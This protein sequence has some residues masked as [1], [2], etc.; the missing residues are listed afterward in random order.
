MLSGGVRVELGA[1]PP[2]EDRQRRRGEILSRV[3]HYDGTQAGLYMGLLCPLRPPGNCASK[4]ARTSAVDTV[5]LRAKGGEGDL[6]GE[7]RGL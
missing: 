1:M 6:S 4:L 5:W 7:V 2:E 3:V